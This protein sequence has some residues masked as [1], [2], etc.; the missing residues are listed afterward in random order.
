LWILTTWPARLYSAAFGFASFLVKTMNSA[1]EMQTLEILAQTNSVRHACIRGQGIIGRIDSLSFPNPWRFLLVIGFLFFLSAGRW[2]PT[3]EAHTEIVSPLDGT[4][5]PRDMAP[6]WFRWRSD[7]LDGIRWSIRFEFEHGQDLL[8][9][10]AMEP[11]WKPSVAAWK[12]IQEHSLTQSVQVTILSYLRDQAEP[13]ESSR[14]ITI[15]TSP[16]EVGASIFF[17]EVSLPLTE[18]ARDPSKIRWRMGSVASSE[19]PALV[20]EGLPVCGNCHSFSADGKTFHLDVDY[21]N[22]SGFVWSEVNTRM[23]LATNDL[24]NWDQLDRK[25]D[26]FGLL[27][28]L[29]PNGDILMA[30]IRDQSVF[31]PIANLNYS[32]LFFPVRGQLGFYHR[33]RETCE[34]L[35][36]ADDPDYVQTNPAWSPDG[37]YVVFARSRVCAGPTNSAG[38]IEAAWLARAFGRRSQSFRYDLCRIPF[39]QGRGG[40]PEPLP[41]ASQNGKS[42]YYPRYSPDGRWIVFCQASNYMMLQPDSE[43]FIIPAGAGR[44]QARQNLPP[45]RRL[46]LGGHVVSSTHRAGTVSGQH[47]HRYAGSGVEHRADRAALA[48]SG[49]TARPGDNLFEVP[50]EGASQS[51]SDRPDAGGGIGPVPQRATRAGSTPYG[52]TGRMGRSARSEDGSEKLPVGMRWFNLCR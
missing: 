49:C 3:L 42:N 30:T 31:R 17:R 14:S 39:N 26:S 29:S 23:R 11:Q 48:E 21:P 4:L 52:Q 34:V 25:I 35:P 41:G 18:A 27:A 19:P 2:S 51:I 28:Q 20:L 13:M 7:P 36:G 37:Q 10:A 22:K 40:R 12:I 1:H 38:R 24:F 45:Q 6:P 16:D 50:G 8:Q 15:W 47:T 32:Q 46:W 44:R 33:G 9:F 5:Y 43:L